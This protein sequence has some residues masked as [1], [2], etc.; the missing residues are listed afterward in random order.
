MAIR[1]PER[2]L[3]LPEVPTVRPSACIRR[4]YS[5]SSARSSGSCIAAHL[6]VSGQTS[7]VVPAISGRS[8]QARPTSTW[9]WSRAGPSTAR[10]E[11]R[12][13]RGGVAEEI[14]AVACDVAED[15]D[16]AVGLGAG[17]AEELDACRLHALVAGVE[18]VD[19]EEEAD[20]P[21]VLVADRRDLVFTVSARE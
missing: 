16:P 21:G 9:R 2:T 7:V 15:D 11:P 1:S 19:A 12:S 14:P 10:D 8:S 20:P 13:G 6:P 17:L 3:R 5:T 4:Q 18:V